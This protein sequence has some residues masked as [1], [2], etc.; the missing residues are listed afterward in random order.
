MKKKT[1]AKLTLLNVTLILLLLCTVVY[2]VR[3]NHTK[4]SEELLSNDQSQT[5]NDAGIGSNQDSSTSTGDIDNEV[6]PVSSPTPTPEE[7]PIILDFAGDVNLD[8]TLAPAQR[9]DKEK[10]GILGGFSRELVD[11]MNAADIMMV[12]NEF[13]YSTRGSKTPDKS[14]TFRA[15]PD[16]V[17]ILKEMGVD[18]VSLAN[19]H[20]LD[21]G[22]DALLDTFD[23]LTQAGIDYIGAGEDLERAKAPVYY[24]IGDKKI[25]YIAAS[26][27]VFAMDWYAADSKPGMIGTYDPAPVLETIRE[28]T[29]NSDFV[30]AFLH[31]GV[32]RSTYPEKYQRDLARQYIDAGADL[33]V[34]CHPHVMQGFEFYKGKPIAYSLG[35]YWF[36]ARE[37]KSGLLKVYLNPD[38]SVQVQILPVMSKS[39]YNFLPSASSERR[40]YFNYLESLSYESVID[41]DGFIKE[42]K[43]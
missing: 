20:A 2:A 22:Q 13:A 40:D 32:E 42:K 6:V 21:Y 17:T 29:T 8:D 10:K 39:A 18:I 31:W 43:K 41:D 26:R 12:N 4:Q 33:V 23:T 1:I 11:E 35:N 14:F 38:D 5:E 27:V 16:R 15:N 24:T 9:Y 19:N 28:A 36:N 7:T 25:A 3:N 30:V 37:Q 34:G